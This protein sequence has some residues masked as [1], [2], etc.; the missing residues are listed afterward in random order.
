[1]LINTIKML[2]KNHPSKS[3]AILQPRIPKEVRE[4]YEKATELYYED[5]KEYIEEYDMEFDKRMKRDEMLLD[6]E[7]VNESELD[8][9]DEEHYKFLE[10]KKEEFE[11]KIYLNEFMRYS[12]G[13]W[14][15]EEAIKKICG[16]II[17]APQYIERIVIKKY[18]MPFFSAIDYK[19]DISQKQNKSVKMGINRKKT[20]GI[21]A[22]DKII[23]ED[24]QSLFEN[25]YFLKEIVGL[26]CLQL[27]TKT[28]ESFFASCSS[29]TK[30]NL[31]SFDTSNVE[32]MANLFDYCRELVR[33]DIANFNTYKVNNM[34]SMFGGCENLEEIDV[35]NFDTYSVKNMSYMFF[36]CKNLKE[37]DLSSFDTRNVEEMQCMFEGCDSL[38]RIIVSDKFVLKNCTMEELFG[39]SYKPGIESIIKYV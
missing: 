22:R 26:E 34:H 28:L 32:N 8:L 25:Y 9:C 21:L 37:L 3:E 36:D 35:S 30:V 29:L 18:K 10:R 13:F 14:G 27:R 23:V 2:F 20:L 6:G 24:G 4:K 5:Y 12:S 16:C 1:M 7:D 38:E 39:S 33:I 19:Y 17:I 31:S 15:I 11:Q